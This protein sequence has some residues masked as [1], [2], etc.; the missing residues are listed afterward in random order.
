MSLSVVARCWQRFRNGFKGLAACHKAGQAGRCCHG[1][2]PCA[3]F[4][5]C[6]DLDDLIV[7]A[8]TNGLARF[9]VVI[10]EAIDD[11]VSWGAVARLGLSRADV[12]GKDGG[13]CGAS[14]KIFHGISLLVGTSSSERSRFSWLF[15]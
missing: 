9:A 13:S 3:G 4:V 15:S 12:C 14:Q 11:G 5:R 10:G 8:K 2:R 1:D 7:C 6:E